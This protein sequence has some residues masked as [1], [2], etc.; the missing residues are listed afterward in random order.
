MTVA[1]VKVQVRA[2]PSRT[3]L[4]PVM[5]VPSA[6]AIC[7][8]PSAVVRSAAMSTRTFSSAACM[9][10]S[11]VTLARPGT[12]T[13]C[14][15]EFRSAAAAATNSAVP[16]AG[17]YSSVALRRAISSGRSKGVVASVAPTV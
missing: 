5:R 10:S 1:P 7:T 16:P 14:V 11:P 15:A 3:R 12:V 4:L 9:P 17:T 2:L 6:R 13:I 8:G